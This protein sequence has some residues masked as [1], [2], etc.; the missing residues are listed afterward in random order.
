M[1]QENQVTFDIST[2][3]NWFICAILYIYISIH[4]MFKL[5]IAKLQLLTFLTVYV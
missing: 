3:V 1:V 5:T 2:K 4:D